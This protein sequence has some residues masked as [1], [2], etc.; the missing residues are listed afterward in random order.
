MALR[1]S[2]RSTDCGRPPGLGLGIRGWTSFHWASVRSVGYF[3]RLIP[4]STPKTRGEVHFSHRLLENGKIGIKHRE[5][6]RKV[7]G[8]RLLFV[9]NVRVSFPRFGEAIPE[10][11]RVQARGGSKTCDNVRRK[12]AE[13]I[14][15]RRDCGLPTGR[16]LGIKPTI[17]YFSKLDS[18]VRSDLQDGEA[19]HSLR[20]VNRPARKARQWTPKKVIEQQVITLARHNAQ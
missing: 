9:A 12:G 18:S 14:D 5:S 8:Q 17:H 11:C 20:C 3:A 10:Q 1:I 2:R 4:F 19:D 16:I 6:E 13:A 7:S 15:E